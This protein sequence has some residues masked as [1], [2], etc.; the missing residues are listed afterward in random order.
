MIHRKVALANPPRR[1]GRIDLRYRWLTVDFLAMTNLNDTDNET[2]IGYRIDDPIRA[3]ANA[4]FIIVAGKFFAAGRPR[5]G[6]KILDALDDA[7][8]VF[9]GSYLDFFGGRRLDQ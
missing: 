5:I 9:L 4:I 3:L 8:T 7:E 1:F 6:G 2:H